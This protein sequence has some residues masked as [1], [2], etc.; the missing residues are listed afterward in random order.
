MGGEA[1]RGTLM[2][3]TMSQP[4]L[5]SEPRRPV[6]SSAPLARGGGGGDC[7]RGHSDLRQGADPV[8]ESH[9]LSERV[10]DRPA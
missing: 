3:G 2:R 8:V 10:A 6:M 1:N 7:G 9:S 4:V 5:Q